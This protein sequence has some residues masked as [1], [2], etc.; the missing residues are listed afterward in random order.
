MIKHVTSNLRIS[1][2]SDLKK[3]SLIT[4]VTKNLSLINNEEKN[5]PLFKPLINKPVNK[6]LT[7]KRISTSFSIIVLTIRIRPKKESPE[8]E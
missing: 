8:K 5:N 7:N 4:H 1:Y 3:R 2:L 6:P